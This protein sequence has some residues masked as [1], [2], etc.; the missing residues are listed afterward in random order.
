M[1]AISRRTLLQ[2]GAAFT[3]WDWTA[4][5]IPAR[6]VAPLVRYNIRS[7]EGEKMLAIYDKAVGE[8]LRRPDKQPCSW[9]FQWYTHMVRDDR[10]KSSEISRIYGSGSSPD[11]AL[12]LA[13]WDTC[14][15]H[16]GQRE[17]F[18]LPWHRL[19]V[20]Y[21]EEIIQRVSGE[22]R[23]TL[24]YWNYTDPSDRALPARFRSPGPLFRAERNPGVNTGTAIDVAGGVPID[25]A[26]MKSAIYTD[27]PSDAGFCSNLDNQVHGAVHVDVGNGVGMG[28]IPWAARD[29][30][31]WLHHC[32][33][34]RIWASW[35]KA[36]GANLNDPAFLAQTFVFADGACEQVTGKVGDVMETEPL[37]YVYDDYLP[38]PPGSA[39]FLVASLAA[40][41]A[42]HAATLQESGPIAL[43]ASL[44]SV[45][46][47]AQQIPQLNV[48]EGPNAFAQ[49]LQAIGPERPYYLRLNDIRAAR[50]PE[51]G[52]DVYLDLP[53][54]AT[55]SRE[56]PSYVGAI[57]FFGATPHHDAE[58]KMPMPTPA[59]AQR[60]ASFVVTDVVARLKAAGRLTEAP[61]VSF[62]PTGRPSDG[63]LPTVGSVAL[64]SS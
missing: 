13:A 38:R 7:R 59:T 49:Q 45:P 47:K 54:G 19:Y 8:M 27:S 41:F 21:F 64:V 43:G 46:L 52:Y 48:P 23:F 17:D 5:A 16:Q 37:G 14:Q 1:T 51:A 12:A 39:P 62:A 44:V 58:M 18:F 55:T 20:L 60:D 31:F 50:Q 57:N 53:E 40:R 6:A 42:L 3:L 35:N 33:I 36:G 24:P 29:P 28:S 34:D 10:S 30:I 15:S 32:N 26:A 61:K 2:T 4:S 11:H 9:L 56:S 22:K 63:S 25:L